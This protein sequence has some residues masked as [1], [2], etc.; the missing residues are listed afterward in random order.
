MILLVVAVSIVAF[1]LMTMSPVGP[2][3]ANVGQAALGSMSQEQKE[4]LEY[5]LNI[6]FQ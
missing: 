6:L 5:F 1:G 3:S 4:K 2:M